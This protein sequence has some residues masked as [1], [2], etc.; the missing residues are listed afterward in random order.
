[1]R[2]PPRIARATRTGRPRRDGDDDEERP[3]PIGLSTGWRP[4]TPSARQVAGPTTPSAVRPWRRWKD[5]TARLVPGPKTPSAPT[6]RRRWA[7]RTLEPRCAR[8]LDAV[9]AREPRKARHVAGPATPSAVSPW[10]R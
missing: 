9:R 6:P 2:L 7:K 5:L 4:A 8:R 3:P 10:R 1:M